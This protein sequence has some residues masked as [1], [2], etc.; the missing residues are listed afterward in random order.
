MHKSWG[1]FLLFLQSSIFLNDLFFFSLSQTFAEAVEKDAIKT[2]ILPM[3]VALSQDDQDSVRLL[4]VD[5]AVALGK[6]LTQVSTT[7][8]FLSRKA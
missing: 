5:A 7:V 2:E 4:T 6:Q 8:F 3:F 1:V